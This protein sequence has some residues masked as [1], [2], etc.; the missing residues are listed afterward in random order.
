MNYYFTG[1]LI[2]LLTLLAFCVKPANARNEYLNNGSST[3]RSGELSASIE[4]EDRDGNYNHY[5][6]TNNYEN[7]DENYRFRIEIRKYL[8]V[9]QRDCKKRNDIALEN[10]QLKQQIELYKICK[11][12][13]ET[14]NPLPQF[15]ELMTYCKG[16][17]KS[18]KRN[19][20]NPY[21]DM[22]KKIK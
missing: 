4:K 21:K 8:G 11:G 12:I 18:E 7:E 6:Y 13:R 9:N 1:T 22:I 5:N 19:N 20:H 15:A 16:T 10:E 14:E 3:C 17:G 2:I